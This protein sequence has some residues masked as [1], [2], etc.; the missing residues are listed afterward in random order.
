MRLLNLTML[1]LSGALL[2]ILSVWAI[3]FYVDMMDEV[4]DSLDDGLENHKMLIIHRAKEDQMVYQKKDFAESNYRL[5][6]VDPEVAI[7]GFETYSDT[8][9]YMVNEEDFEIVRMLTTYFQDN[10]G[11]YY[12]L[13]VISSMVEEDDLISSLLYSIIT[14]FVVVLVSIFVIN[15]LILSRVWR[16]FYQLKN[17]LSRFK[18]GKDNSFM[19][20][21]TSVVEFKE[22]NLAIDKLLK[23]NTEVYDKQKSFIEN[24]SHELQTP[25]AISQSK[26]EMLLPDFEENEKVLNQLSDIL[27]QLDR[28]KRLNK[29]LLL[30]TKIENR[31]FREYASID[32]NLLW[33]DQIEAFKELLQHK[34]IA[35]HIEEKGQLSCQF[36]P[37]LAAMLVSNLLKNAMVHN[38]YGGLIKV[39]VGENR[40]T[41][42]NTG[43]NSAL[44]AKSIFDRFYK[45]V[46]NQQSTGLGLAIVKSIVEQ[47]QGKVVYQYQ[48]DMHT[49]E[50]V[51]E[52]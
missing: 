49:F 29:T 4:Y 28:M 46:E 8:S 17:E 30:L 23:E 10:D 43:N 27:V 15:K 12:K 16:P 45:D 34:S 37:D 11:Q 2:L 51:F 35:I 20:P 19:A 33:K 31:Q 13:Q 38:V 26:V 24:A 21:Q 1:Y 41:I 22:L 14:L 7:N 9:M 25:L 39:C 52:R 5:T 40:F 36:N 42:A 47:E 6:P 32:F 48:N 44:D 50:V 3:V 18:L